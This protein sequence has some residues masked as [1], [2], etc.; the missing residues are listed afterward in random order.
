MNDPTDLRNFDIRANDDFDIVGHLGAIAAHEAYTG[1]PTAAPQPVPLDE[2]FDEAGRPLVG[3]A[4]ARALA[5]KAEEMLSNRRPDDA[6]RMPRLDERKQALHRG[7]QLARD[8][9]ALFTG[10]SDERSQ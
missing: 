3:V 1:Q 8:V 7:A 6:A 4:R 2:V 9:D 10:S 5:A